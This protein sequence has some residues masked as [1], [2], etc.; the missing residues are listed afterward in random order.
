MGFSGPQKLAIQS[1]DPAK[2]SQRRDAHEDEGLFGRLIP[3]VLAEIST[4][5][6]TGIVQTQKSL[7]PAPNALYRTDQIVA[8]IDDIATIDNLS[9]VSED[10][11]KGR[12]KAVASQRPST[13]HSTSLYKTRL[14]T[15]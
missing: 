7:A 15:T 4:M 13:Y 3:L 2:E 8:S 10:T 14:T 5:G 11:W 6:D 12:A 1:D 9:E